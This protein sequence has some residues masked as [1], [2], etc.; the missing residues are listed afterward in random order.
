MRIVRRIEDFPSLKKNTVA[1]IGNFD[2]IHIGHK[3]ILQSLVSEAKKHNLFSLVLT[4]SPHPERYF[5]KKPVKMI[6]T[7][8]QRLEEIEKFD[9]HMTCVLPFSKDIANLRSQDFIQK[10]L[11][12]KLSAVEIIVGHNFRFGKN[13][14]GDVKELHRLSA[15]WDFKFLSIPSEKI[16][17]RVISSS[18]IRRFLLKGEIEEAN[19]FL[20]HPYVIEGTVIKGQSRGKNLGFPTANISCKNEIIPHGLY[21]SYTVSQ[22]QR[23][24]SLTNIGTS[25]T[26][27]PSETHV[28]SHIIDFNENL[29]GQS[30]KIQLLKKLRDEIE[31]RH[32]DK[33][34]EQ[35]K[36][37]LAA[38]RTYF[39][40]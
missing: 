17:G 26:F 13:R 38:A 25:P 32:P 20:G 1:A 28:E 37:D 33:L 40:Q 30:Q 34:V 5:G 24:P 4:F 18:L 7:I 22:G 31:F 27:G 12:D 8:D 2:G 16:E 9:I 23:R 29:Y 10:I 11:M 3:R 6:Q 35:M 19:A 39:K 36:K 21:L 15:L 14:T